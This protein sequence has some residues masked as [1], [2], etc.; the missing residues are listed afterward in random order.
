MNRSVGTGAMAFGAT[1]A[2]IGAVMRY[3]VSVHTNG[4]NIHMA[5]VILLL[6]GIGLMLFGSIAF[7]RAQRQE[8]DQSAERAEH[9]AG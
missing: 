2:V 5:G 9:A 3:A 8:Y 6:A 4:F 7:P 1:L